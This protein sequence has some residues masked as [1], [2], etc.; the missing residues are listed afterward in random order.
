MG[1]AGPPAA[2]ICLD[3]INREEELRKGDVVLSFVTEV[4]KFMQ[5]GFAASCH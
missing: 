1:Y 2:L 5:A 4:S 3:K